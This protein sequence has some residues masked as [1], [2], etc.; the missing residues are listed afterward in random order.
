MYIIWALPTSQAGFLFS[1]GLDIYSE[2]GYII[3]PRKRIGRKAS[4][5]YTECK[6]I[7]V[8]VLMDG[9][10]GDGFLEAALGKV[11]LR[12]MGLSW[13][14]NKSLVDGKLCDYL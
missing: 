11:V 4:G 9:E 6:F 7:W 8:V 2:L 10:A 14:G 5:S 13:C 1:E 12:K 3:V